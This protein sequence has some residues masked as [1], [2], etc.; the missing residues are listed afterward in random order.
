MS[1]QD[2]Q[3]ILRSTGVRIFFLDL[4]SLLEEILGSI[5]EA[6]GA[7]T[8]NCWEMR[9]GVACIGSDSC[10]IAVLIIITSSWSDFMSRE[11]HCI[12]ILRRWLWWR[13]WWW[14]CPSDG[15]GDDDGKESIP[16]SSAGIILF[17]SQ[18]MK[19]KKMQ[20]NKLCLD[21]LW[22]FFPVVSLLLFL[23][24]LHLVC[25]PLCFLPI[26]VNLF[27]SVAWLLRLWL[28]TNCNPSDLEMHD[29][30]GM[31]CFFCL[32]LCYCCNLLN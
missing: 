12:G 9:G 8:M 14:W 17:V 23:F 2:H 3:W 32:L 31:R 20:K 30:Y 24:F 25:F 21:Q 10:L 26:A 11:R 5:L 1:L 6:T 15:E 4:I 13:L 19:K 29:R 22:L 28:P 18:M 27:F 7:I 16:S